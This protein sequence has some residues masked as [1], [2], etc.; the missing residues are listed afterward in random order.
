[1]SKTFR[2]VEGDIRRIV[3]EGVRNN[4]SRDDIRSRI[5]EYLRS[6]HLQQKMIDELLSEAV[7]QFT[8]MQDRTLSPFAREATSEI[9]A[10]AAPQYAKMNGAINNGVFRVVQQA[11]TEGQGIKHI[12]NLVA[13]VMGKVEANATTIATTAL[14]AFGRASTFANA[15][16]A[17][18]D[19]YTFLGPPAERIF[20]AKLL[21][22]AKAGKIWTMAEIMALDNGQGLPVMFY[23]GG[24]NCRHKW[25]IVV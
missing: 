20:C 7:Q 14:G 9:L 12:D 17:G 11:L 23:C 25:Q 10:N 21:A 16:I 24:Y 22:E 2:T 6:K 13:S 4:I 3:T 1:M 8:W 5:T 18:T 15:T 19:R